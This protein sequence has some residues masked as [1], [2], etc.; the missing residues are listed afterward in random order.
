MKATAISLT[1]LLSFCVHV[2]SFHFIMEDIGR[3]TTIPCPL[4]D[5]NISN[6]RI[7]V[8][9]KALPPSLMESQTSLVFSPLTDADHGR[10]YSCQGDSTREIVYY[11]FTMVALGENRPPS[12]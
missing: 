3:S 8:D 11:N 12:N 5:E 7:T 9:D 1:S 10:R 2:G 6:V 4:Q